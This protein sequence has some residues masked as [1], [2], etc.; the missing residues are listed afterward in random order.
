MDHLIHNPDLTASV[1]YGLGWVY[2]L[3][4]I[5]NSFWAHRSLVHDGMCNIRMGGLLGEG[6]KVPYAAFWA[7]YAGLLLMVAITHLTGWNNPQQFSLVMPEILKTPI[8]KA[9]NPVAFFVGSMTIYILMIVLRK[10][11]TTPTAGWLLLNFSILFL[12]LSITDY[13]FR[14]IVGKPDNVPIVAMLYIVGFFTW[15]YFK[16]SVENDARKAAG[17]PLIEQENNEKVL[18]W[19]DLVYTELVCMV[20]VTAV[21]IAWGIVLQAPLEEPASAAKTPNPSKAPWYFLGLQ[22]MLVYFD[23]WMAGVVLPSVILVGL[24]AVPYIDFNKLG[25]GYYTFN[26]RKFAV[27]TFLFGFLPLWVAMIVLGTFLRGPNWNFFSPYEY[28]DVHKLELLNNI[29]LS[30]L[31]WIEWLGMQLPAVPPGATFA[32]QAPIIILREFVGLLAVALY[33]L[34]LPNLM[35]ITVFR[36]FY[37]RMGFLR[38]MVLAN[39]ML[40]MMSLPIKMVLRW[41]VNL[42]Y[43]VAIPEWF[44]NI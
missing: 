22:E 15:L 5:M 13:D 12:A 26:E 1:I 31:F 9:S 23:P 8:N 10:W 19:P 25:N 17:K 33:L 6:Q 43:I 44:F 27:S 24:M 29:N 36:S 14:Q 30:E 32:V 18:T 39:L 41:A 42:K 35:A 3:L 28:W 2:L 40:M 21:L 4:F 37:I 11:W 20:L 38:Y 34:A 16:K 7:L